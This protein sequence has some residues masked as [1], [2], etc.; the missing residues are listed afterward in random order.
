MSKTVESVPINPSVKRPVAVSALDFFTPAQIPRHPDQIQIPVTAEVPLLCCCRKEVREAVASGVQK[1]SGRNDTAIS[2]GLELVA[3]ERYLSEI[4]QPFTDSARQLFRDYCQRS[5]MTEREEEERWRWCCSKNPTPSCSPSGIE[6]CIRGWLKREHLS[7]RQSPVASRQSP[8]NSQVAIHNNLQE[9]E[10]LML[11]DKDKADTMQIGQDM[12]E[13][14]PETALVALKLTKKILE[15]I[16]WQ[17]KTNPHLSKKLAIDIDKPTSVEIVVDGQTAYQSIEGRKPSLN[18]VSLEDLNVVNTAL[19]L[20]EGESLDPPR[21]LSIR[22]NDQ[23]VLKVEQG[24]VKLN[25]LS[26]QLEQNLSGAKENNMPSQTDQQPMTQIGI[27]SGSVADPTQLSPSTAQPV[28]TT[29]DSTVKRMGATKSPFK[30]LPPP[31]VVAKSSS[32]RSSQPL[33][34]LSAADREKML[35]SG[36]DPTAIE[37]QVNQT[38]SAYQSPQPD[39]VQYVPVVILAEQKIDKAK[40]QNRFSQLI[41]SISRA[42]QKLTEALKSGLD[43]IKNAF[44]PSQS[45]SFAQLQLPRSS[46]ESRRSD[47]NN[48]AALSTAQQVLHNLGSLKEDGVQVFTGEH[49]QFVQKNGSLSVEAFRRGTILDWDAEAGTLKGHLSQQDVEIFRG[50]DAALSREKTNVA[51]VDR[52]NR[53]RTNKKEGMEI[54]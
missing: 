29:F 8:V 25:L 38:L 30:P 20:Q 4:G 13:I 45:R 27:D 23:E 26:T 3:V 54:G 47:L 34:Q 50:F 16:E 22:I 39:L 41:N 32:S 51:T 5:G 42:S 7:S 9:G 46:Q 49:Y 10:N 14:P 18:S 11:Q 52:P 36:I 21:N 19:T 33:F 2:V 31:S 28:Q 6:A 40:T 53:E 35:N 44:S 43:K 37:T 1:G 48:I 15:T 12:Q 17:V 24:K